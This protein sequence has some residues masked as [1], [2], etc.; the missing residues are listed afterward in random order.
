VQEDITDIAVA[1]Q[2]I[3]SADFVYKEQKNSSDFFDLYNSPSTIP[4]L[5]IANEFPIALNRAPRTNQAIYIRCNDA[6]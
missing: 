5:V 4:F 3:M 2:Q 1:S 6:Q